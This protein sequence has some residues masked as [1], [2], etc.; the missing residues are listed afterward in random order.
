MH[1]FK[2]N[3]N[4]YEKIIDYCK[5][6]RINDIN[7]FCEECLNYGFNVVRFGSSPFDNLRREEKGITNFSQ[8][9][10]VQE[11]KASPKAKIKIIKK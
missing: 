4:L 7:T 11:V 6:N 1:Q 5:L 10:H 9:E 2:I 3:N 8:E